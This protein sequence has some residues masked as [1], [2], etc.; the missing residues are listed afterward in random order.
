MKFHLNAD[1]LWVY[2]EPVLSGAIWDHLEF[3][4]ALRSYLE[5]PEANLGLSGAVYLEPSRAIWSH[6]KLSRTIWSCLELSGAMWA[7]WV[8]LDVSG[9][10]WNSLGLWL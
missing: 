4:G 5:L 7:I 3:F 2:L 10:L 8:H 1:D 6:L 9:V